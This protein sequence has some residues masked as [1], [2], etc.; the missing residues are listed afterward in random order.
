VLLD[1]ID[2]VEDRRGGDAFGF[3]IAALQPRCDC[4]GMFPLSLWCISQFGKGIVRMR[5]PGQ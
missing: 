3:R 4:H 2:E 1:R 5:V